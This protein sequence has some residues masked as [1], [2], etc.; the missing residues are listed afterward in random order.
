MINFPPLILRSV[1]LSHA[2]LTQLTLMQ[3]VLAILVMFR[4][5]PS[6]I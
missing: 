6:A 5:M 2:G 3:S 4:R 1:V